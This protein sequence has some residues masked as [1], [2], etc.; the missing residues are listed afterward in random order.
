VR[1][2]AGEPRIVEPGKATEL[3]W[4]TRD[5]LRSR[6]DELFAPLRRFLEA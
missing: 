1:R 2:V 5:E 4:F 3:A 6:R